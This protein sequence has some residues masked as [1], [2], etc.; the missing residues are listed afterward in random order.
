MASPRPAWLSCTVTGILLAGRNTSLCHCSGLPEAPGLCVDRVGFPAFF[1]PKSL[2]CPA[3]QAWREL[4]PRAVL[5]L[6]VSQSQAPAAPWGLYPGAKGASEG[7]GGVCC[8]GRAWGRGPTTT[9]LWFQ[10]WVS[11]GRMGRAMVQHPAST[12][13][14]LLWHPACVGCSKGRKR[15]AE[16]EGAQIKGIGKGVGTLLQV[17]TTTAP[18]LPLGM[19]HLW[20]CTSGH[21]ILDTLPPP[22]H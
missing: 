6:S 7:G 2:L 22:H 8:H 12:P 4:G 16:G 9:W 1:L 13:W 18:L 17:F 14:V 20:P 19:E 11:A 15:T 3:G 5:V 10:L 21:V